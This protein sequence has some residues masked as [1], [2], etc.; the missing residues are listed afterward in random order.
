MTVLVASGEFT[1]SDQSAGLSVD[2]Y[3]PA[4]IPFQPQ[5]MYFDASYRGGPDGPFPIYYG[6]T[7]NAASGDV[8]R[9]ISTSQGLALYHGT[10]GSVRQMAFMSEVPYAHSGGTE[11]HRAAGPHVVG[12]YGYNHFVLPGI[13]TGTLHSY[14]LA[15]GNYDF[16]IRWAVPRDGVGG[17]TTWPA[18]G[19]VRWLAVG[20]TDITDTA[21]AVWALDTNNATSWS[22]DVTDETTG[23]PI[24]FKPDFLF[25][26]YWDA[27]EVLTG[28]NGHHHGIGWANC[29]LEQVT[30]SVQDATFVTTTEAYNWQQN[31]ALAV[32]RQDTGKQLVRLT[33][34]L[35]AGGFRVAVDNPNGILPS[36]N[37]SLCSLAVKG[38]SSKIGT[39]T[40]PATAVPRTGVNGAALLTASCG[41][42]EN[43]TEDIL[44]H[45][46]LSWGVYTADSQWT[47]GHDMPHG[48]NFSP[49]AAC[50]G[51]H[52]TDY[53]DSIIV[54]LSSPGGTGMALPGGLA[55]V[56][57]R[58]HATA[59][60]TLVWD[61]T[62]GSAMEVLTCLIGSG[63]GGTCGSTP[64]VS[65]P[66]Q[67][68]ECVI[69]PLCP[70]EEDP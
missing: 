5:F 13:L 27:A 47:I 65:V 17:A 28:V 54:K 64:G 10:P 12:F 21:L 2:Q 18:G 26:L 33:E 16:T 19:L 23:V 8:W 31:D 43:T 40:M 39:V 11:N 52:T 63:G 6:V 41:A 3:V 24:G 4:Q 30:A 62:D 20:G 36:A 15:T 58:A 46:R 57:A 44:E 25:T 51:C 60:N 49:A 29:A 70:E 68:R 45:H 42:A 61:T 32:S 37:F 53:D 35:D 59:V 55:S 50:G 69:S 66:A 48:Q 56:V 9:A 22:Q 1:H 34:M 67:Q 14:T 38:L 7:D